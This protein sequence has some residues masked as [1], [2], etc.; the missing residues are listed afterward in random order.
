MQDELK[1]CRCETFSNPDTFYK[2]IGFPEL[3]K[4]NE[5]KARLGSISQ[6]KLDEIKKISGPAYKLLTEDLIFLLGE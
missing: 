1:K 6:S 2:Q 4:R 5:I 3:C